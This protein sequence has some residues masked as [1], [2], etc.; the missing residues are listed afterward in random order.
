MLEV[1]NCFSVL[2][3]CV[4]WW[5]D[6][7]LADMCSRQVAERNMKQDPLTLGPQLV[8]WKMMYTAAAIV[9]AA[10]WPYRL[11]LW[12]FAKI[13]N[14]GLAPRG[15]R[16][17][18]EV[19]GQL[20]RRTAYKFKVVACHSLT[21]HEEFIRHRMLCIALNFRNHAMTSLIRNRGTYHFWE[22]ARFQ[23]LKQLSLL[24]QY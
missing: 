14:G 15:G 18:L 20:L 2:G 10:D 7:A 3:D 24:R 19:A 17:C 11:L 9:D 5:W 22:H 13:L 1:R 16:S 4:C 8:M 21:T 6:F 12:S 23:L